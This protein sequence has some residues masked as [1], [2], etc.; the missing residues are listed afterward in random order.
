MGAKKDMLNTI[1]LHGGMFG[2]GVA[3]PRLFETNIFFL[4][5]QAAKAKNIIGVYGRSPDGRRLWGNSPNHFLRAASSLENAQK[6]MGIDWMDWDEIKE[7]IPPAYTEYIGK[8]LLES[9]EGQSL[10]GKQGE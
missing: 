1:K 3:R 2:L 5:N 9:I 7:A 4:T 8:Y 10:N 6:A